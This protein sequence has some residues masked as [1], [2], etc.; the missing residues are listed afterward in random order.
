MEQAN[1][2][3]LEFFAVLGFEEIDIE[4]GLTAL[5]F[6]ESPDSEYALITDEEGSL[7]N[8]LEIPLMLACYSP[9]G[10]FLW[11]T[12]FKNAAHCK[13]L[14]SSGNTYAE[15]LQKIQVYRKSVTIEG[16]SS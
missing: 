8:S 3:V 13:E 5:C 4:D 9:E 7:P 15:K 16:L 11:S 14:W 1:S 10:A 12:G 2:Q 6:E